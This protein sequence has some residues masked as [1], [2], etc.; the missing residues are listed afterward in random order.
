MELGRLN[1]GQESTAEQDLSNPSIQLESFKFPVSI[2][3]IKYCKG[4]SLAE[5][6]KKLI[7][8][9]VTCLKAEC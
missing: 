1:R 4:K 3:I 8:D 9:Y 5:G 7:W 6:R 2:C